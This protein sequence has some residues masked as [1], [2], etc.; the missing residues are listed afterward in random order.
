M[1]FI[2]LDI[3]PLIVDEEGV[4][5]ADARIVIDYAPTTVDRY[6]H[7]AI[8]PYPNHLVEEWLLPDGSSITIRPVRPED[9]EMEREFFNTLSDESRYFRFMDTIRELSKPQLVRFTQIDYDRDM[10]FVAVQIN[11]EEKPEQI[12]V[13]RYVAN[14]DGETVE[15]ALTVAD[16]WQK[17]GLGRKLMQV[18]ID[19]ARS[20]GFSAV[21]GEVLSDNTKMLNLMSSLGFK[22]LPNPED[23]TINRT[24]AQNGVYAVTLGN[25]N[26]KPYARV[27]VNDM[28][29]KAAI[30]HSFQ[31]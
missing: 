27:F 31:P 10:A 15:F 19:C 6:A 20:K 16:S 23:N 4:I 28:R 3:N 14:P 26:L 8:H 21:V 24:D 30:R 25:P 5:A 9:A 17:R 12:G 29:L 11:D 2:E 1:L 7:M 18:L 13:S 22:I